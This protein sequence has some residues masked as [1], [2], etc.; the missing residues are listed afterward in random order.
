MASTLRYENSLPQGFCE[1][2]IQGDW[3]LQRMKSGRCLTQ[4]EQYPTPTLL[5]H[6][7]SEFRKLTSQ[8]QDGYCNNCLPCRVTYSLSA[9]D[10]SLLVG[11][12]GA[13]L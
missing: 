11:H 5:A 4:S 1:D 12:R 13:H 8:Q 7:K 6:L 2:G 9:E 10:N 3:D